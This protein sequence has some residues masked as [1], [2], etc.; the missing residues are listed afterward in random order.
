MITR[1]GLISVVLALALA[2]CGGGGMPDT[3]S[4]PARQVTSPDEIRLAVGEE[5]R[6]DG[7][8]RI[9]FTG[10]PGDSRCPASVICIWQGDAAVEI[11]YGL[12]Q[13]PS[14]P[15]TLHTTLDPKSAS[16]AGYRITLLEVGPYPYTTD[17]IPMDE[18]EIRVRVER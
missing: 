13:G 14:Y 2:G 11:H 5:V 7:L 17:P 8:L 4:G 6:V 12:G 1:T 3:V 9:G 10:V 15:D 18:Y 16:F